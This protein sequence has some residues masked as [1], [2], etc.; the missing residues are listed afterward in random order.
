MLLDICHTLS[1][2]L[3]DESSNTVF[4]Q[5]GP[6]QQAAATVHSARV[7]SPIP[8]DQLSALAHLGPSVKLLLGCAQQ[9][10]HQRAHNIECRSELEHRGKGAGLLHNEPG[11]C[12][13]AGKDA[14][15]LVCRGDSW[16]QLLQAAVVMELTT[17]LPTWPK[18]YYTGAA[19]R[20]KLLA[21]H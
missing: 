5:A 10:P 13:Q 15:L 11:G 7:R 18:S 19:A 9:V 1:H 21:S 12:K 2:T 20:F 16:D 6:H 3:R 14:A 17:L 4:S 8:A